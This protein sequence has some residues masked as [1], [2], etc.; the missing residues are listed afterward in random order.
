M[1]T[2]I[3]LIMTTL[4]CISLNVYGKT[5]SMEHLSKIHA[6]EAQ[7]PF[8]LN[9]NIDSEKEF[10]FDDEKIDLKIEGNTLYLGCIEEGITLDIH[11][12]KLHDLKLRESKKVI[13]KSRANSTLKV[14]VDD[15]SSLKLKGV[16]TLPI[17]IVKGYSSVFTDGRF[18]IRR[19]ENLSLGVL[20]LKGLIG[21]EIF[22]KNIN[23]SKTVS[24]QGYVDVI[25]VEQKGKGYI[26]IWNRNENSTMIL[27]AS[28]SGDVKLI[29][30]ANKLQANLSDSVLLDAFEFF[31]DTIYIKTYH[32]SLA[33]IHPLSRLFAA[34]FHASRIDYNH[35]P[36]DLYVF[37]K[38]N[39]RVFALN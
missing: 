35:V 4:M 19:L 17:L 30:Y 24:L 37:P 13:V 15:V 8:N 22:I 28:E 1:K 25:R 29:G 39:G 34:A 3:R 36:S 23:N 9:I 7:G 10:Y 2:F 18:N 32:N 21:N 5:I 38:G 16:F 26:S 14:M 33:K 6:I 27:N 31:A 12:R 11:V 20:N